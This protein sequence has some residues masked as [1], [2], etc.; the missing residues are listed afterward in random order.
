MMTMMTITIIICKGVCKSKER[1]ENLRL[2]LGNVD[3]GARHAADQ[4]HAATRL[5]AHEMASNAGGPEVGAIDID[6]PQLAHAVDGVV[7]G[8]EVLGEAG[9]GDEV[10]DLSVGLDDLIDAGLDG[11]WVGDV[12]VVSRHIGDAKAQRMSIFNLSSLL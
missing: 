3:N 1:G 11:I 10:V 7:D 5:A 9:R 12:T 4:D 8:L 2:G 6:G